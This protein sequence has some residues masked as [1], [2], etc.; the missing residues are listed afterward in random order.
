MHERPIDP[1]FNRQR[2]IEKR[3]VGGTEVEVVTELVIETALPLV[4]TQDRNK[5][6][7]SNHQFIPESAHLKVF[8]DEVTILGKLSLP[9]RTVQIFSRL[10]HARADGG[11]GPAISVD[12]PELPEK[13]AKPK[14]LPKGESPP[15]KPTKIKVRKGKKGEDGYNERVEPAW[16]Q[17]EK[18]EAGQ[19]GW[20]GRDHPNEMEGE[21][22]RDG[23]KGLAAGAIFILCGETQ[24]GATL[25]LSA[26]GGPGGDGQPGQDGADGG[27]GGKGFDAEV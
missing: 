22:G 7:E 27:D 17:G 5:A 19:S 20:S 13:L 14:A 26:V 8:G 18:M 24:F 9:G 10:L 1:T 15:D 6:N 4:L 25:T 21:P 12:G 3:T 23:E 2:T 16:L 11:V